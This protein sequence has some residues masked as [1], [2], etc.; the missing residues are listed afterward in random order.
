MRYF[1]VFRKLEDGVES[2]DVFEV[3]DTLYE[4]MHDTLRDV[5]EERPMP[6]GEEMDDCPMCGKKTEQIIQC[7]QCGAIGCVERCHPAGVGCICPI[8]EEKKMD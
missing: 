8:C 6:G 1:I 7:P 3:N 5:I 4:I 2:D